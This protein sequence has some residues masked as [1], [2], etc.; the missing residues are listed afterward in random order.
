MITIKL[1]R[2]QL[3]L[4]I[5][6]VAV[7]SIGYWAWASHIFGMG[8]YPGGITKATYRFERADI[9]PSTYTMEIKPNGSKFDI[10]ETI[11]TKG[12]KADEVGSGFGASGAA[13][14]ARARFEATR[15]ENID[16]SPLAVFD[17]KE[18]EI[19]PND[20]YLLP[21][22]AILQTGD[23]SQMVG[24]EVINAVYTHPNFPSQ[25]V[26]MALPVDQAINDV[27]LYPPL[28]ERQKDGKMFT[29]VKLIE[30]TRQK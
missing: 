21:D 30:L 6:A 24:I 17:E 25:R 18:I 14:A 22:G 13:G 28:L 10:F 4:F 5:G 3:A 12:R 8:V 11:E 2:L 15:G 7:A 1:S 23:K 20:K 27:L 26:V 19:K 16:L 29:R 9:G